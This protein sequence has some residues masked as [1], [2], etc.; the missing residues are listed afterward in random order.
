MRVAAAVSHLW[1]PDHN[2]GERGSSDGAVEGRR[3]AVKPFSPDAAIVNFYREVRGECGSVCLQ[4]STS[5][6]LTPPCQGD[7]LG[8][9]LDDVEA[10]MDQPIVSARGMIWYAEVQGRCKQADEHQACLLEP[11]SLSSLCR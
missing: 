3:S 4:S 7:T 5:C 9:H 8:G 10:D 11:L 6:P 2:D 1:H